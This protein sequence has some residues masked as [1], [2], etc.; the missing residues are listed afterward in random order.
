ML[1]KKDKITAMWEEDG[2]LMRI[3]NFFKS[4]SPSETLKNRIKEKT[5]RKISVS[6]DSLVTIIPESEQPNKDKTRRRNFFSLVNKKPIIKIASAAAVLVLAVYLGVSG[7]LLVEN[8][9]KDGGVALNLQKG[10]TEQSLVYDAAGTGSAAETPNSPE[11]AYSS[12]GSDAL[13]LRNMQPAEASKENSVVPQKLIYT[14]DVIIKT[15]NVIETVETIQQSVKSVGG[16]VVDSSINNDQ[17]QVTAHITIKVPAKEFDV[18]K[19]NLKQFGHIEN[20]HLSTSDVSKEYFDTETRLKSW[21]AQ[22]E[23]YLEILKKANTVEEILRIEDYLHNV[24]LQIESLKGQLK[25]WDN[26]VDYSEIRMNIY[27]LQSELKVKDPWQPVSIKNTFIAAKN[28]LL[29]SINFIWNAL[30]YLIVFIGYAL[31]VLI[32]LAIIWVGW[33]LVKRYRKK[34]N[35]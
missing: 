29:K 20:Q 5:L 11:I 22:E 27:P 35:N 6:E 21:Q 13:I 10:E 33:I 31:P 32:I 9:G 23:R 30:N 7:L 16:Y 18:F 26:Q 17:Y 28:A 34:T 8:P 15:S 2:D 12:D 19:N 4:I 1:M 25:Y 3:E 24:R 14:M